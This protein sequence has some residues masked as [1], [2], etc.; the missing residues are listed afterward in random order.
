MGWIIEVGD[1]TKAKTLTLEEVLRQGYNLLFDNNKMILQVSFN[2]T[3]VTHYMVGMNLFTASPK[4]R[5][6]FLSPIMI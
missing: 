5:P 1:G 3:G 6:I 2:A 4:Y